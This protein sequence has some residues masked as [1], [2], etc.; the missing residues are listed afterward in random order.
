MTCARRAA[1]AAGKYRGAQTGRA[2]DEARNLG[3]GDACETSRA[4]ETAATGRRGANFIHRARYSETSLC[5]MDFAQGA[6]HGGTITSLFRPMLSSARHR[7]PLLVLPLIGLFTSCTH[8]GSPV[9]SGSKPEAPLPPLPYVVGADLSF[10][11][12]A[13]ARGTRFKDNG[14]V[15][16]GLQIFRDH[17]YSWIRLRLFH[18]PTRLPNNLDYTI[19]LAKRAKALG[20]R[21]LLDFHYSDTWADPA[22]QVIPKAWEGK[23]HAEL[24][25][26]VEEYT[27]RSIEAFRA[28]DVM[29]DMVQPGNEITEGMMWPDGK[30]PQNWDN[31]AD[32]VKAGIR[33]VE[34]GRGSAPRPRIL[35]QI[36]RPGS[37]E[38]T[39]TFFDNLLQRGVQFDVI[40]QSY[41]PWWHGSLLEV[42]ECLAF[43]AKRYHKDIIL[44]EVAYNWRPREYREVPPPFPET[45]EGQRDFLEEVNRMVLETPDGLGKGVFWW[46]AAVPAGGI[47]SRGMFDEQ[48]N[49]LPVISV[50]DKFTRGKVPKKE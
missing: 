30:L 27:R 37:I 12:Q 29:P 18:S 17:G 33:G 19:E 28:A 20:Y 8:T 26:A 9:A 31:F 23:S 41:Y 47:S 15:K 3:T 45:P 4:R 1:L 35:I 40:G 38:V 24:V 11:G 39:G 34:A 25:A 36:E 10:L 44:V 2:H 42:R 22:H 32:L 21:F 6:A 46:E 43:T 13:E 5:G 14:V 16:P 49:A 7:L 48:G 50:F